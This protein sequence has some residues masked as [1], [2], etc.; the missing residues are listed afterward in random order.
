MAIAQYCSVGSRQ[1]PISQSP[2]ECR[3]KW[4]AC[5]AG[6]TTLH[7]ES[8]TLPV[9]PGLQPST[10]G[11]FYS[12]SMDSKDI[13]KDLRKAVSVIR[14]KGLDV[15]EML[16][17]IQDHAADIDIELPESFEEQKKREIR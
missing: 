17:E 3:I 10:E 4:P 8:P 16:E 7:S 6:F 15:F 13:D 14:L 12:K 9:S 1:S 11:F 2:A 5:A